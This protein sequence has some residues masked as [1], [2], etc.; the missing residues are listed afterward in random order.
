MI[1]DSTP[2]ICR[3]LLVRPVGMSPDRWDA[4]VQ[5]MMALSD[6]NVVL[7]G[8]V[9]PHPTQDILIVAE[10]DGIPIVSTIKDIP[11]GSFTHLVLED[12]HPDVLS[13]AGPPWPRIS[14]PVITLLSEQVSS[15][16]YLMAVLTRYRA[17]AQSLTNLIPLERSLPYESLICNSLR[18]LLSAPAVAYCEARTR[19]RSVYIRTSDPEDYFHQDSSFPLTEAVR[20]ILQ[21]RDRYFDELDPEKTGILHLPQTGATKVIIFKL[22][23]EAAPIIP[24]LMIFPPPF[25]ADNHIPEME[26]Q[27]AL[28]LSA[29][30]LETSHALFAHRIALKRKSEHDPLT[31][32]LNRDS[33]E[34]FLSFAFQNA[35]SNRESL[36]ILMMD[37]DHFKQVNDTYGH[38]V[39]DS[40]LVDVT[41]A[42]GKTLRSGD[43][44]GRYGGEEFIV[45]LPGLGKSRAILIGERIRNSVK[46]L[47]HPLAGKITISIG[48]ASYP[49]DVARESE[50]IPLAD[51]MMYEAKR[52][53]RDRVQAR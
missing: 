33:M 49:E 25:P 12:S 23:Q 50:L 35:R 4:I 26:F 9:D 8:V 14:F 43:G 41:S 21:T 11:E 53:G 37:I 13:S 40:V 19:S 24:F 6:Q 46:R 18:P 48:I 38:G 22:V 27:N 7:A 2:P 17:F 39:G 32:I 20:A 10:M 29:P 42:I 52:N 34:A 30:V 31:K 45:I 28:E 36:S 16:N 51:Q 47:I 44:F 1:N 15:K 3:I 5:T